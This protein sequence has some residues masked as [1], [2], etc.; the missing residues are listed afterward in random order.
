M[1]ERG[2]PTNRGE[3]ERPKHT[4]TKPYKKGDREEMKDNPNESGEEKR[5]SR[6]WLPMK[7]SSREGISECHVTQPWPRAA[8]ARLAERRASPSQIC[9]D[10]TPRIHPRP[11][12]LVLDAGTG[13]R[14]NA[15]CLA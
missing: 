14:R 15:Y 7:G 11:R 5:R 9:H 6:K 3:R 12:C 4:G 2:S 10:F 1:K 8:A 13:V